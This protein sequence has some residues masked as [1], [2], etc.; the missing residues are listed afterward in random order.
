L[1]SAREVLEALETRYLTCFSA[2]G[3]WVFADPPT[4]VLKSNAP[5]GVFGV[6]ADP[7]EANAPDPNPN[8]LDAPAVGEA[9]EVAEGDMALKGFLLLWDERSPCLRT[10]ENDRVDSF[11]AE[12]PLELEAP[13]VKESLLELIVF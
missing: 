8:A 6:F 11:V 12:V 1:I 4:A 7:K 3:V 10:E 13:V 2:V 9:N 5:P